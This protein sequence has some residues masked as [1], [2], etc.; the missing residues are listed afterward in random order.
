M[1]EEKKKVEEEEE[2]EEQEE[3]EEK[4]KKKKKKNSPSTN[5]FPSSLPKKLSTQFFKFLASSFSFPAPPSS[6]LPLFF[7]VFVWA[8]LGIVTTT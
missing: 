4:K 2:E 1:K 7:S 8:I 3:E 5:P 6:P